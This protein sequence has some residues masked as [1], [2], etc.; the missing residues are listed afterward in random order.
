M[1]PRRALLILMAAS[2]GAAAGCGESHMR[3]PLAPGSMNRGPAGPGTGGNVGN[4]IV[5][6]EFD[7]LARMIPHHEEAIAAARHLRAGTA[8]QEMR[9]FADAIVRTQSA[10]VIQ[11]Q[12]WLA[13]WY[14]GRDAS[15]TYQPMMRDLT[16]LT[17]GALDRAFLEDM[18]PHHMMAVAM[19][20]QLLVRGPAAHPDVVPFAARIRDTQREEILMMNAWLRLWFGA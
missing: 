8:R 4:M 20:Q 9:D 3:S 13:E 1:I 10:E 18:I 6:G 19:S 2:I 7:Y 12:A 15:V 14:P 11:M 5:T 16:G 17:A